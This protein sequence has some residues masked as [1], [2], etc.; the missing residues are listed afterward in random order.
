M[1]L[2][3][4]IV[5]DEPLARKGM[6]EYVNEITFLNLAGSC[7]NALKAASRLSEGNIDLMLLDIQMPKLSGIDFLKTLKNP[8]L[9]IFTTAFSQYALESY[10]LDV[11]D[12]LVKPIPF[13]RFL[14]AVQKAFDFHALRLKAGAEPADDFFFIKCDHKF[15]KVNYTDVLYVESMQNYCIIH[16]PDRKLITYI[17]LGNLEEQLPANRFLKVH[18]SFIVSLEKIKALDGHDILIGSARVPI[19]RGIKDEVTAK[20]MGNHLFKRS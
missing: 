12:Y 11:I 16:T 13:D 14:K 7:E 6:E 10:S 4:L 3:C 5:D 2:N 1:K 15:E 20:I 17:T 9:V 8:P 18:K 19:S